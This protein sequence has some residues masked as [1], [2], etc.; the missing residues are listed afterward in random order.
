MNKKTILT[1]EILIILFAIFLLIGKASDKK[2]EQQVVNEFENTTPT[3]LSEET[4]TTTTTTTRKTTQKTT[5]RRVNRQT[6]FNIKASVSEMKTYAKNKVIA[7]W[8]ESEWGA[9]ENIVQ[10]ESGW[11]P[12]AINKSSGACG[13]FQMFPCK[14]TNGAYKTSYEAQIETGINYIASRYKTPSKAWKFWQQ[15]HW[16]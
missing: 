14:K 9:F 10:R 1:I 12:N 4:T 6:S 5:Q 2:K 8:G 3:E 11:N 15:H 16:Y 7:K 13:L